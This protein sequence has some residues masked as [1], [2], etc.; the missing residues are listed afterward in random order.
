MVPQWAMAATVTW[1]DDLPK[2]IA[3]ARQLTWLFQN[4]VGNAL[5]YRRQDADPKVHIGG[6]EVNGEFESFERDNGIGIEPRFFDRVFEIFKRLHGRKEYSG[7]GIGLAICKRV[8][9][10]FGGRIWIESTLGEGSTFY[11]TLRLS[12]SDQ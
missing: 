3:D 6:R 1:D 7:T 5:K 2:V 9:E 10:R 4:I 11:F 12:R 8:V